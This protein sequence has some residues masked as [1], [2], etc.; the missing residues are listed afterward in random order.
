[1]SA[2]VFGPNDWRPLTHASVPAI[3]SSI[4]TVQ[5]SA[6]KDNGDQCLNRAMHGQLFCS[7]HGGTVLQV[8]EQ[9]RRR[10]DTVRSA[11]FD[12][13]VNAAEEAVDTYIEI[14]RNGKRD[15]DKLKAA[16]RVLEMLGVRDQVIEVK[17]THS[18]EPTDIEREILGLLKNTTKEKLDDIIDIEEHPEATEVA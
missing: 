14:M 5:C 4:P 13:L 16:D 2:E 8:Q 6:I 1:M 18:L 11:M 9:T 3:A 17:H 7:S 15:A 12:T 10:L